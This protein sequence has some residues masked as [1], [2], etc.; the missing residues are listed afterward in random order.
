[1]AIFFTSDWH[2]LDQRM[3]FLR[4]PFANGEEMVENIINEYNSKVSDDDTVYVLGDIFSKDHS[5]DGAIL[6]RLKGHKILVKGNHD[7]HPDEEYSPYFE[8]IVA[9]G[10]GIELDVAGLPCY[11]TH[12]PTCSRADRFNLVGHVHGIWRVAKNALNVGVDVHYYR[13]VSEDEVLFFYNA[14]CNHYDDDAWIASHP[15]M[16]A[17]D[18]R[19]RKGSYYK[20]NVQEGEDKQEGK[21]NE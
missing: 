21:V 20:G 14:I 16:T 9:E 6:S 10:D 5:V 7:I 11:L 15:A 1:M 13:P 8:R 3:H 19:G 12:Y 4:R 18:D 17:H 2:F